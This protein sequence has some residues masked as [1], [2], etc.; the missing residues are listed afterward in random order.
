MTAPVGTRSFTTKESVAS[1][2]N[3]KRWVEEIVSE[4]GSDFQLEH[5]LTISDIVGEDNNEYAYLQNGKSS[6]Y[7]AD[8]G[9]IFYKGKLIGVCEHKYQDADKNAVERA[10][11]Y[12]MILPRHSV[13]IST[14]GY[15]FSEEAMRKQSTA[16]AKFVAI[17]RYGHKRLGLE[18]GVGFS[19]NEG[20]NAFKD[21]FRDWFEYLISKET[22]YY[23]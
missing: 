6:V 4:Y 11:K 8:G 1:E 20:G 13:F 14:S 2:L 17:A 10:A 15:G 3:H 19:L 7:E 16:T 12:L 5:K 22:D 23:S 9:W 18:K 21:T